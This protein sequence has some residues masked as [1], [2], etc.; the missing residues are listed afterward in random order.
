MQELN[1]NDLRFILALARSESLAEASRKL[2]VNETTVARRVKKAEKLLKTRLFERTGGVFSPTKA[3]EIVVA[4]C[5]R[6]EVETQNMEYAVSGV[7]HLVAGTVRLTTVP[8]LLNQILAADLKG[9]VAEHPDLR[10]E[11]VA[12]PRDLSLMKRE[13]D[14][15]IRLARPTRESGAIARRV[16][17]LDYAVYVHKDQDT[18]SIPWITYDSRM[19]YLPQSHWIEDQMK[20]DNSQKIVTANDAETILACVKA[21]IGKSL[22]PIVIA[23]MDSNLIKIDTSTTISR[24]IWLMTHPELKKLPRIRVAMDWLVEI[25]ESIAMKQKDHIL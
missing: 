18:S 7:D 6:V 19:G 3:G 21:G 22:L 1:W 10:I 15:A 24:E 14:I 8:V 16:G 12:E 23:S 20:K 13:T 17:H 11:L 2:G 5:E 4:S 25:F 9:L